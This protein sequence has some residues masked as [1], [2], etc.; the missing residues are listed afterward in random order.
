MKY[1]L[2]TQWPPTKDYPYGQREHVW[3]KAGQEHAGKDLKAGDLVFI[4]EFK[5]GKPRSDGLAYWTGKQGIV[6]LAVILDVNLKAGFDQSHEKYSDGSEVVWKRVAHARIINSLY[7]CHHDVVCNCLGYSKSY[8]LTG[9][10]RS[11]LRE[12]NEAEF[13]CLLLHFK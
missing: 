11:G 3:L 4:Y 1:W 12:L 6:T 9:F 10:G 7:F 2:T 13:G 8:F 5:T